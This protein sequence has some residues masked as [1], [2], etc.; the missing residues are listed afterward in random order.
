MK[1][2][3]LWEHENE[4]CYCCS[5]SHGYLSNVWSC[6]A[7]THIVRTRQQNNRSSFTSFG[8]ISC[9]SLNR[10]LRI[11]KAWKE[12]TWNWW[13]NW[14]ETSGW[15]LGKTR[16]LWIFTQKCKWAKIFKSITYFF[17]EQQQSTTYRIRSHYQSKLSTLKRMLSLYQERMDQKNTDLEKQN[18]VSP[19]L[20]I[21]CS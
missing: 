9:T 19:S 4:Q 11:L 15:K 6:R 3:S 2:C 12:S 20:L 21:I 14:R 10:L 1:Q 8:F 18:V 17:C 7:S 13:R 16:S 5:L